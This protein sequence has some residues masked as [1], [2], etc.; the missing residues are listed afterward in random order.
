MSEQQAEDYHVILGK[1][2][3]ELVNMAVAK[4]DGRMEDEQR[5]AQKLLICLGKQLCASGGVFDRFFHCLS[6]QQQTQNILLTQDDKKECEKSVKQFDRCLF[7]QL[8][9]LRPGVFDEE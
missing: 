8:P 5:E 3:Q 1:C 2:P 6:Q 4:R 7:S 9:S